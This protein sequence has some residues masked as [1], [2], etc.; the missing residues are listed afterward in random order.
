MPLCCFLPITLT[1]AGE[2]K[3]WFIQYK[4][5]SMGTYFIELRKVLHSIL[6][7]FKI[8]DEQEK[9]SML[10]NLERMLSSVANFWLHHVLIPISHEMD[11]PDDTVCYCNSKFEGYRRCF[12]D[13]IAFS[14]FNEEANYPV[15]VDLFTGPPS[16]NINVACQNEVDI[17]RFK[18]FYTHTLNL[19]NERPCCK[20]CP[21]SKTY[22][23]DLKR[24]II[25]NKQIITEM[26][27]GETT[28]HTI[29]D[30]SYEDDNGESAEEESSEKEPLENSSS[31]VQL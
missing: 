12:N 10:D 11:I 8:E 13:I 21:I 7:T 20:C 23:N 22:I 4:S 18:R 17:E 14:H 26:K 30:E 15:K 25:V 27:T 6:Q 3:R 29:S 19:Y 31:N 2:T 16:I 5:L 28:N 9:I 1:H 24:L